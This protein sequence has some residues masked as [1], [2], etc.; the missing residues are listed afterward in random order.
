MSICFV[1]WRARHWSVITSIIKSVCV[2]VE[3]TDSLWHSIWHHI[4]YRTRYR[5]T[6]RSI[7][8]VISPHRFQ[9]NLTCIL[10]KE[11]KFWL[12][13][14]KLTSLSSYLFVQVHNMVRTR[15]KSMFIERQNHQDLF[16]AIVEKARNRRPIDA[17]R[18]P[19]KQII[20]KQQRKAKRN[21]MTFERILL[22]MK[23]NLSKVNTIER[24]FCLFQE[25]LF[26][27]QHAVMDSIFMNRFPIAIYPIAHRNNQA[28]LIK[29]MKQ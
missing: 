18:S 12:N 17:H 24:C 27:F 19:R 8:S 21:S 28:L 13:S 3:S 14:T 15:S 4:L 1:Y 20:S 22:E 5:S 10:K 7:E 6:W 25:I 11:D 29:F 26:I 9:F 16:D 2:C 23:E